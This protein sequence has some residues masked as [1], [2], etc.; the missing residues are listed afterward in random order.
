M[1]KLKFFKSWTVWEIMTN[2]LDYEYGIPPETVKQAFEHNKSFMSID[3]KFIFRIYYRRDHK[4]YQLF[5]KEV[6]KDYAQQSF[7]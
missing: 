2:Y 1:S 4:N 7:V 3:Q 6:E 5:R